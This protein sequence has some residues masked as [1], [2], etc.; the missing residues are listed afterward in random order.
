[1]IDFSAQREWEEGGCSRQKMGWLLQDY[2][3]LEDAGS[4]RHITSLAPVTRCLIVFK[5]P[6]LGKPKL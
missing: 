4:V 5:I 6:L 3:P 1:M 2:C